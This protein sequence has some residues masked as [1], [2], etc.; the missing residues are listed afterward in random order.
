MLSQGLS[1]HLHEADDAEKNDTKHTAETVGRNCV[2]R[3][4]PTAVSVT[5][6]AIYDMCNAENLGIILSDIRLLQRQG[7]RSGDQKRVQM[8]P[9]ASICQRMKALY[10]SVV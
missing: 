8:E 5:L 7:E 6:P 9:C 2:E 3:E 10:Y 4:T 1:L